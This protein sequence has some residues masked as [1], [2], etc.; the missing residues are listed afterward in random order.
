MGY[1]AVRKAR[2]RSLLIVI[3]EGGNIAAQSTNYRSSKK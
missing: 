1:D 3:G 2:I